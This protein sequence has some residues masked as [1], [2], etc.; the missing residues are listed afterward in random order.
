MTK[1]LVLALFG[2]LIPPAY[3]DQGSFTNSG[4][5][6]LVSSGVGI[7]SDVATPAGTLTLDCPTTGTGTCAGGSFTYLSNDGT[8]TISASFTSGT[9]TESCSGGGRGGHITCSYR[10]IGY[11]SGTWTTNGTAQA[12]IGVTYQGFGTGGAPASGTTAYNSAYTPFYYSDSEQILRSDDL[13]GTNQVSFGSQ[14][15]GVGQFYGAYGIALD[16]TGRIYVADTYNCRIVRIDD[17]NGTNWTSYGGTCGSGQGQFYDPSGIAVDSAGEIYVMD[18]GNS[19]VVRMDDMSG[20]N[21]ISYGT[22]GS[23]VGQF[24]Q[25]LTSVAVD[26]SGRIYVADTGNKRVVRMDDM[27]GS[28]WTALTQS[29]PV[30]GVSYYFLQSPAAVAVDSAGRIYVA[31]NE[32]YAPAVVRVDDMSGANWTFIYTSPSGSTGLNSI[33]A[34][35]SGIV[36][37]G[38]GGVRIIDNMAGILTSS[39]AIAPY[40]TYY[41]FGV[42]P[43]ALPSPRPSA[44]SFSPPTLTFSQNL[45]TTS[46]SQP[47]TIANFGGS[48]L[49]L[50]SI[51]TSGGFAETNNC[52]NQL[53]AG[54]N[55]TVNL[56]FTPS[57]TGPVSGSLT[58]AD[59]SGNLGAAQTVTLTGLGL[60]DTPTPS[61]TP[62]VTSDDTTATPTNTH[63]PTQP[64]ADTPTPTATYGV[65]GHVRYYASGLALEAVDV[66]MDDVTSQ[67]ASTDASGA[68]AFTGLSEGNWT[69]TPQSQSAVGSAISTLDAVFALETVV[70]SGQLNAQQTI[71][72]DTSGDGSV[73]A[74]DAVYILQYVV[75]LIQNF[76][77]TQPCGSPWVFVPTPAST[78]MNEELIT[79]AIVQGIC[80]HGAMVFPQLVSEADNQDFAGVVVGDCNGNW[81]PATGAA[82]LS[83]LPSA[84]QVRFARPRRGRGGRIRFPLLLESGEPF[85]ALDSRISYDAARLQLVAVRRMNAAGKALVQYNANV[86]GEVRIALASANPIVS[87]SDPVLALDFVR[88][89]SGRLAPLRVLRVSVDGRPAAAIAVDER[90]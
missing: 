5:S 29:P 67:V 3:A 16:A 88:R 64:V 27:N 85:Q 71:A 78:I 41:V 49:N 70:G 90:R 1:A 51:S 61:L 21:W 45:G 52:P 73:T 53:L 30:N 42:T 4:G 84:A 55:C 65:S 48:P 69:L 10:F 63:T 72:C 33:S 66:H 60:T 19:R 59:D 9:Y 23:G 83:E 57:A 82:V 34:D 8:N 38:G 46:A 76:P 25:Y 62:T 26:A 77:A 79:P 89:A 47:L 81:Q 54:S 56:T 24:A 86:P 74:V 32:Y 43:V 7:S 18:T 17:M 68:F 36:F 12:I 22:V 58:V 6:T 39:G 44:I 50:G 40:G 20:T 37:T 80:Q 2:I 28:N 35:S 75:G 15:S 13:Q 11:I 14:G 31:D 87:T